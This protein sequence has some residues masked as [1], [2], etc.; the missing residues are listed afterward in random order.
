M[1]VSL[2]ELINL[3]LT[4]VAILLSAFLTFKHVKVS[5][6]FR[7]FTVFVASLIVAVATTLTPPLNEV[8]SLPWITALYVN[9]VW[10]YGTEPKTTS[11]KIFATNPA[12][13]R[14]F[15]GLV[16][17]VIASWLS[18]SGYNVGVALIIVLIYTLLGAYKERELM[19]TA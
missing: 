15:L 2:P 10:Y 11:K 6:S 13:T 17:L 7:D 3:S 14:V 19:K 9:G 8:P 5:T 1:C 4:S 12:V 18:M 16:L